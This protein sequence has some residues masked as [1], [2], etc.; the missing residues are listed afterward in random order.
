MSNASK[1]PEGTPTPSTASLPSYQEWL[2]FFQATLRQE[3]PL[4]NAPGF[5][6]DRTEKFLK[7][8]EVWRAEL[9]AQRGSRP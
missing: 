6:A 3:L 2:D 5:L 7:A 8:R 9:L 1:P 4:V